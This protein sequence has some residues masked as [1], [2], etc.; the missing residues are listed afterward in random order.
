MSFTPQSYQTIQANINAQKAAQPDLAPLTSTSKVAYWN[1]W[2]FIFAVASN[3]LQQIWAIL[4]DEIESDVAVAAPESAPWI[5]AQVLKF[6]YSVSTPQVVQ[7]N[8]DFSVSY[9]TIDPTLEIITNCAVVPTGVGGVLIKLTDN[10]V[11]LDGAPGT[12]GP[13]VVALI[14]YLN[15]ILGSDIVFSIVNANTDI[16]AIFGTVYYNGQNVNISSTVSTAI[17]NYLSTLPFNA[18]IKLSDIIGVIRNV[19]GVTD[20]LPTTITA[21]ANGG[22]AIN[23]ILSELIIVREYQVYSGIIKIDPGNPLSSSL[24]YAISNN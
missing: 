6:Q 3:L 17:T 1:L 13:Q 14:S 16:L 4:V 2:T 7:L 18:V 12:A 10:G 19:P 9:P 23:L 21:T 22:T 20:F 11:P 8:S 5:Q 24:T 15:T